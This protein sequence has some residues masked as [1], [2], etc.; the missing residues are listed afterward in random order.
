MYRALLTSIFHFFWKKNPKG[1]FL[2]TNYSS[3][4]FV[5]F[6]ISNAGFLFKMSNVELMHHSTLLT[7]THLAFHLM[8]HF[9]VNVCSTIYNSYCALNDGLLYFYFLDLLF[10]YFYLFHWES[11]DNPQTYLSGYAAT[12]APTTTLITYVQSPLIVNYRKKDSF[13]YCNDVEIV[14]R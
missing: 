2:Y 12:L 5:L 10:N 1:H 6:C 14:N 11:N 13:N 3:C 8:L 4:V 7:C 9:V